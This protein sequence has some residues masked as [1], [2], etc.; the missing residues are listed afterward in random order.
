MPK[1]SRRQSQ[2]LAAGEA[3][4]AMRQR[5]E[6]EV[7]Q[8]IE[9]ANR[10]AEAAMKR[11][12][13]LRTLLNSTE[14]GQHVLE[15]EFDEENKTTEFLRENKAE[16]EDHRISLKPTKGHTMKLTETL[17]FLRLFWSLKLLPGF[18]FKSKTALLKMCSCK[19]RKLP[20]IKAATETHAL[21]SSIVQKC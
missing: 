4:A 17:V 8:G 20:S 21:G 3:S 14:A 10:K 18:T 11:Y 15:I 7:A 16:V 19:L 2:S 9:K 1:R 12:Q 13:R 6:A 5:V